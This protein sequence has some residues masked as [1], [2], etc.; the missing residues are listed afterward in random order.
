MGSAAGARDVVAALRLFHCSFAFRAVLEPMLFLH[1][2]EC[3]VLARGTVFVFGAC[4]AFVKVVTGR[5]DCGDAFQTCV[6]SG[7]DVGAI[8]L[9]AVWSRAEAEDMWAATDVGGE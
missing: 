4:Q 6:D 7:G 2:L 1:L 9:A 3:F 5:A 8:D